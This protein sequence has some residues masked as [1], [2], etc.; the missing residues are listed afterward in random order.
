M[1]PTRFRVFA[2]FVLLLYTSVLLAGCKS[3]TAPPPEQRNEKPEMKQMRNNK[4][5]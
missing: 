2:L 3:T 1:K 4:E 5:G